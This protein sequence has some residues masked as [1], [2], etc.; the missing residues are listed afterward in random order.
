MMDGSK[1]SEFEIERDAFSAKELKVKMKQAR[2]LF[3]KKMCLYGI[4]Y[5]PHQL[6]INLFCF[7][8]IF[9]KSQLGT[10]G[11]IIFLVYLLYYLS[12]NLVET[13]T[14]I[15]SIKFYL[16]KIQKIKFNHKTKKSF[17]SC[18]INTEI[19]PNYFECV[20]ETR[21]RSG[22][23]STWLFQTLVW[24]K[25]SLCERIYVWISSCSIGFF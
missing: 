16:L 15:F 7:F 10:R 6:I 2:W 9:W 25:A 8:R 20:W 18:K 1:P 12:W 23:F 17:R 14:L 5:W 24:I 3:K 13:V 21:W 4:W 19:K 11:N 22:F